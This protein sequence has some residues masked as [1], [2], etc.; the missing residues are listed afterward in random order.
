MTPA[1]L[2]SADLLLAKI[3][4]LFNRKLALQNDYLRQENKILRGKLGKRV[5]LNDRE[6]RLLVKYGLRIKDHLDEVV[7]IVRPK[8]CFPGIG[9]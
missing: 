4:N 1:L 8:P 9:A 7:S 3:K 2:D 6:R 5:A